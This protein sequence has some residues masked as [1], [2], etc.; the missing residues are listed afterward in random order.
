MTLLR[1]VPAI[2]IGTQPAAKAYLG[3][4]Q[5]W[6]KGGSGIPMPV[7]D[8]PGW[9]RRFYD[10]GVDAVFSDFPGVAVAARP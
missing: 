5:I 7:G 1:N 4:T 3:A 8:L 10:L 2:Y 6:P 9:T